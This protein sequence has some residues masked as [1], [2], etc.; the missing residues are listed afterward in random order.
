[1]PTLSELLI[2]LAGPSLCSQVRAFSEIDR[3]KLESKLAGFE[4][5]VPGFR[6]GITETDPDPSFS[7]FV[8]QGATPSTTSLLARSITGQVPK[9]LTGNSTPPQPP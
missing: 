3:A 5:E 4:R 6:L 9:I 7:A 2:S 1:M 8:G